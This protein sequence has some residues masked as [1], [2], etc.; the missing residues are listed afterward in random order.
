MGVR[1]E[2]RST[3]HWQDNTLIERRRMRNDR[4]KRKRLLS[5]KRNRKTKADAIIKGLVDR[6]KN[7][8]RQKERL[9]FL[10]RKYYDKWKQ[11]KEVVKSVREN[12]MTL[13]SS[14]H[15]KD[16]NESDVQL[17]QGVFGQCLKKYYKGISIAVKLFNHISSENV[18]Q[19]ANSMALSYHTPIP[20]IFGVNVTRKPYFLVS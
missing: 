14:R 2:V 11:N 20:H 13:S 7:E 10:A 9:R 12:T 5:R 6:L 15:P 4:K 16:A 19:E 8:S 17:G 18:K 3:F 1:K